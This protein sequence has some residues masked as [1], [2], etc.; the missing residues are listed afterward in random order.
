MT[1]EKLKVLFIDDDIELGNLVSTVLQSEYN[2]IVHF[3][4]TMVGLEHM[5][6]SFDPDIIIL[7]VEVGK[8]NGIEK[9]KEII[10]QY[11]NTP[12]IFVSAH[13]EDNLINEGISIGGNAYLA[14]PLTISILASYIN[15]FTIFAGRDKIIKIVNYDLN[16]TKS[17]LFHNGELI[18][19]LSPFESKALE[20]FMRYPFKTIT[21]EQISQ[22]LWGHSLM[23]S[24]TASIHNI[25]S[26]LRDLFKTFNSVQ[27][28]TVRGVGYM[29]EY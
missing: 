3:Q 11:P 28:N 8:D 19:E 15:R 18:K 20:L 10:S 22:K 2:F 27:I 7:D 14:K 17:K 4:N 16:L 29:L 5:I 24:K 23:E 12:I 25:V 9:A 6:Y 26:K 21:H 13:T 1:M